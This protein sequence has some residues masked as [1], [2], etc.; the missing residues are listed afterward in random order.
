MKKTAII[1]IVISIVTNCSE[2]KAY[3]NKIYYSLTY[4]QSYLLQYNNLIRGYIK[5]NNNENKKKRL[6]EA[7]RGTHWITVR[8]QKKELSSLIKW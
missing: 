5:K 1:R 4:L 7:I 8:H 3:S 2:L 6:R